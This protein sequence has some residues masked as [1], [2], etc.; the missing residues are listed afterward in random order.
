MLKASGCQVLAAD[1][2]IAKLELARK[3]GAD[4]VVLP[5][6]LEEASNGFSQGYG[7]DAVIITAGSKENDLVEIAGEITRK[8]G[9]VV[10]VGAVGMNLP[11]EPY[12]KKELELRLSAS[13]GPGRYDPEYEEKGRDYPIGYVRWTEKR[14]MEAFLTLIQQKRINLKP[15]ITHQFSIDH[16]EEAYKLMMEG[17]EPYLG[18]LISYPYSEEKP[19]LERVIQFSSTDS[20]KQIN[21]GIIG[22]GNH[23]K[24][25]L[26]PRLI[27]LPGV[28]I[29]SIC[30]GSGIH[31]KAIAEKVKASF[32]TSDYREVLNDEAVNVVIIGTRHNI[33]V[34]MVVEALQAG[35]HVFVEKPLCLTEEEL[36]KI[37]SIYEE[38]SAPA[39]QL[40]VGFNRRFSPHME[41]AKDFFKDRC[42]PLVMVYRVNAG[43]L[44]ITHWS[45]DPEIGGGRIIGE[46]CHFIDYMQELCS[47]PPV[48]VQARRI[49][50]S[51]SRITDDQSILL[52]TFAD[53][54]VGT[55]V[56]AAGGDTSLAKE[57]FEAFGDGKSLVMTDFNL[58][59]FYSGGKG[60][61]FKTSK[62]DKGFQSEMTGFIQSIL[63]GRPFMK[64]EG[65]KR[66]TR[67][68]MLAVK[69][70]RT[71]EVYEL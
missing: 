45:Q 67:A 70:M 48:S 58:S 44:P 38:K 33:Y 62:R 37:S 64:F 36:E 32:C 61:T 56:Y 12:Y 24:D 19:I 68:S 20:I 59:E 69:S 8:K 10:I 23:V 11:R 1:L 2:D 15:L 60:R 40:A 14:N 17:S 63:N 35:K 26:L 29:R 27:E 18:I 50:H 39:L 71:G 3:S 34:H 6:G 54:S 53:G 25:M 65:I 49:S 22:A 66:V 41:V 28:A 51:S 9:R 55:V 5:G 21:I 46:A 47:A 31:A 43:A 30:T 13:Y 42:N 7:V 52:L 16:A 57:R 4:R